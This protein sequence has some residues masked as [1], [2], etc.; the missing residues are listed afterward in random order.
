ML[1]PHIIIPA[2]WI[3]WA[4]SWLA[5]GAW[6]SPAE[7][8]V[9]FG[10]ELAYRIPIILGAV[11]FAFP[12]HGYE[13]PLRL[14]HIGLYGAWICTGLVAAGFLFCWWARIYLGRLWSGTITKKA[15]HR[16]VDTGPYGIVRHPI[17][18]G[19]LLALFGTMAAKGTILGV[20]GLAVITIGFWLKARLEEK[21][22][23]EQLGAEAY[24]AYAKRV[25][26]LVPF[27]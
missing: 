5:A 10:T 9:S 18:T 26:M 25:P 17:Y 3:C 13:G 12:A 16:V 11:I 21:F 4:V 7:K 8:R 20:A 23:R 6:A 2:L 14:W 27:A 24:D 15:D 19:L 22:L 1:S